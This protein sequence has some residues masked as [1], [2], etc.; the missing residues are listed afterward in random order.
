MTKS[1][2]GISSTI[3]ENLDLH[4]AITYEKS[5]ISMTGPNKVEDYETKQFLGEYVI[6]KPNMFAFA[7]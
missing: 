4:H 2:T 5:G 6:F 7:F 1:F 3:R